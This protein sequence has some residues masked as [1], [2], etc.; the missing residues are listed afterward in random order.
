MGM[1]DIFRLHTL[2][3]S[4]L[5][6]WVAIGLECLSWYEQ[7]HSS[8]IWAPQQLKV[9]LGYVFLT[10]LVFFFLRLSWLMHHIENSKW[11]Y[12]NI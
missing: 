11:F 8:Q 7:E 5:R 1:G 12:N 2:S 4:H 6:A 10:L 9:S 3:L